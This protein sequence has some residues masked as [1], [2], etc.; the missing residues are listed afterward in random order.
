MGP[1]AVAQGLQS[2]GSAAMAH[3]PSRSA[4]HG[5]LLDQG[6]N[7]H[8]Q[9]WQADSPP[10]RHQ[11]SPY[12]KFVHFDPIH[13]FCPPSP[14]PY[15]QPLA[16]TNLFFSVSIS[17]FSFTVILLFS[18]R[19]VHICSQKS[20]LSCPVESKKSSN[21]SL[22]HPVLIPFNSDWQCFCLYNL[23]ISLSSDGPTISLVLSS[24]YTFSFFEIWT[25]W[26]FSKSLKFVSFLLNNSFF[27]SSLLEFYCK[28]ARGNKLLLQCFA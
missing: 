4:A 7:L 3:G 18:W 22:F 2:T 20:L 5:I 13:P 14:T 27:N 16:T 23:I 19:I 24:E 12:W 8:R 26:E 28:E 25:G 17:L 15:P 11:G 1:V 9:H 10:L 21:L 6:L